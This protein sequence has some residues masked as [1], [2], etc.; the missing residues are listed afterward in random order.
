LNAIITGAV[1]DWKSD[2][3]ALGVLLYEMTTLRSPFDDV[4]SDAAAVA[5]LDDAGGDNQSDAVDADIDVGGTASSGG[6]SGSGRRPPKSRGVSSKSGNAATSTPAMS[7]RSKRIRQRIGKGHFAP[8]DPS[9][10]PGM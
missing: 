9:F 4:D 2:V 7:L 8:I 6:D 3:W 10:S 1:P 5:A